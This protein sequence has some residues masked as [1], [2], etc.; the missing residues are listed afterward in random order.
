MRLCLLLCLPLIFGFTLPRGTE[1]EII[2]DKFIQNGMR[3]DIYYFYHKD[4]PSTFINTL[5]ELLK[6]ESGE[7]VT[8]YL[9]EDALS[10]GLVTDKHF[11][12]VIVQHRFSSAGTEG[13]FTKTNLKPVKV[14]EPPM[15]LPNAFKL[16]GHTVD[17]AGK[18]QTWVFTTKHDMVWVSNSIK[19]HNLALVNKD[20]SGNTLLEGN[21]GRS[22]VQ[23]SLSNSDRGT[24]LVIV[25]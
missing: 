24:S 19:Q 9:D 6:N 20:L 5:I 13:F 2:G 4:K 17:P 14:P 18:K 16:V 12:N 11:T 21:V 23:V 25:Q 7:V 3:M 15:D 10:V 1:V 8:R 22:K